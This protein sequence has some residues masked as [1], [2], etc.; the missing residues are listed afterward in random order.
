MK[1]LLLPQAEQVLAPADDGSISLFAGNAKIKRSKGSR[2]AID[3][4]GLPVG[5]HEGSGSLHWAFAV[6]QPGRYR[7][8][9]LTNR[10]WS[11]EWVEGIH[12]EV[13]VAGE[14]LKTTLCP[15][16]ALDN[17]QLKY[18]PETISRI[19]VFELGQPGMHDLKLIVDHMPEYDLGDPLCEDLDEGRTLNL[20][21]LRLVPEDENEMA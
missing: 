7:L 8:E 17:I 5:F 20:I 18:H 19:G 6:E 15:D 14:T 12:V 3:R 10:H 11:H 21:E 4:K 13:E 16:A 1:R 9:A 2:L